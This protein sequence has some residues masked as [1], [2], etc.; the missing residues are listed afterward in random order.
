MSVNAPTGAM[1]LLD[2]ELRL[3]LEALDKHQP[4]DGA[5]QELKFRAIKKLRQELEI[6]ER[7]FVAR[8]EQDNEKQSG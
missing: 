2:T 7:P 8:K 5:N 1:T 3:I 6:K 4:L